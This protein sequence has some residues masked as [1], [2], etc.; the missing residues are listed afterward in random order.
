MTNQKLI[1]NPAQETEGRNPKEKPKNQVGGVFSD[2]AVP[3]FHRHAERV[4]Q[5][6]DHL[7]MK[8]KDNEQFVFLELGA[9]NVLI[10]ADDKRHTECEAPQNF[11][12]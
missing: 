5:N 7:K 12:G 2:M 11:T 3:L 4:I 10:G 6:L 1:S 9:E 8:K